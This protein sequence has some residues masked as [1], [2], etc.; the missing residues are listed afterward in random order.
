MG[1]DDG[2]VDGLE[3]SSFIRA[4]ARSVT[5]MG[6]FLVR[7]VSVFS[8]NCAAAEK[9]RFKL[10]G[11]FEYCVPN[12]WVFVLVLVLV[13]VY[14]LVNALSVLDGIV[15][16]LLDEQAVPVPNALIRLP[17]RLVPSL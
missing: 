8:S 6:A 2:V 5:M 16:V 15:H 12:L 1:G 9:F 10:F 3:R 7:R 11:V 13:L 14:V 4:A 17:H